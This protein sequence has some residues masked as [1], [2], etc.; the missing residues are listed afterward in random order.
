MKKAIGILALLL[1]IATASQGQVLV[2]NPVNPRYFAHGESTE[3]VYLT[4]SHTWNIVVTDDTV[5]P[6]YADMEKY[7]DWVQSFGH[8][9]IR[10]WTNRSYNTHTP[11]PWTLV[12]GDA[13]MGA[14]MN[15]RW[16]ENYF[17]HLADRVRQ[18]TS[19]GM[20]CSVM[21]FGSG[22]G[23]KDDWQGGTY[24]HPDY[25]TS[26][27]LD[28]AF[29]ATNGDSFY[30]ADAA[31]LE[32]Q[33]ALVRKT[34]DTLS[35]EDNLF[36]EVIN[37]PSLPA[38]A[39]WH[40]TMIAYVRNYERSKQKQHLIMMSGEGAAPSASDESLLFRSSAD[41]ISPDNLSPYL[42]TQGGD[43]AYS[44]KIVMNDTD[45]IAGYS[46][47]E[48]ADLYRRWV[49]RAFCRGTN[50]IF[51]DP[52]DDNIPPYNFGSVNPVF[53]S[54]RAAMGDTKSYA[55][56][57]DLRY[58][59]PSAS[60]SSTGYAL[61]HPGR[62]YLVYQPNRGSFTYSLPAGNYNYEWFDPATGR[63]TT[64]GTMKGAKKIKSVPPPGYSDAVLFVVNRP[65]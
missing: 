33:K 48:D 4:G 26:S 6:A 38:S 61:V 9:Y 35:H 52:Y 55:D 17:T 18:V 31:A 23:F 30:T 60:F 5:D 46:E 39:A 42:I 49:W 56:R 2:K 10:L 28:T 36:W 25:N 7:L 65:Q 40:E 27:A 45:H 34:I 8:N 14:E 19:R 1:F 24:W 54:V 21:L 37:E 11:V 53:D 44:S 50:V 47:P 63:V 51:M 12:D 13:V 15:G 22:V 41:I 29:S 62:T 58:A 3:A 59:L 57:M 43:A 64:T 20:Y 32:V 16:N